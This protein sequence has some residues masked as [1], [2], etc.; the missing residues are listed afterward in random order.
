MAL[1][2][3]CNLLLLLYAWMLEEELALQIVPSVEEIEEIR[4]NWTVAKSKYMPEGM[5]ILG[6]GNPD[7]SYGTDFVKW[8]SPIVMEWVNGMF[9]ILFVSVRFSVCIHM[10]KRSIL[11]P[12]SANYTQIISKL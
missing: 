8:I 11:Y 12:L 7:D 1:K 5:F 9:A 4:S 3:P 10:K 6:G 2:E